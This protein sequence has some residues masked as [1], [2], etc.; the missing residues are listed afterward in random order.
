MAR[1]T[2]TGPLLPRPLPAPSC[3]GAQPPPAPPRSSS[4]D[5]NPNST[6]FRCVCHTRGPPSSQS[7]PS[8]S[9]TLSLLP[10][11]TFGVLVSGRVGRTL[12]W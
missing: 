5:I 3:L 8:S 11:L 7:V 10:V 12:D 4:L 2:A 9:I 6:F 1:L